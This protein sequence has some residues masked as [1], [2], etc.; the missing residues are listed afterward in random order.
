MILLLLILSIHVLPNGEARI[1]FTP[2][3]PVGIVNGEV[4][5][6][7]DQSVFGGIVAV[8]VSGAA[9]DESGVV[10]LG[11][12]RAQI[13]FGSPT[14]SI[15]VIAGR[16]ILTIR[17]RLKGEPKPESI[18]IAIGPSRWS[19]VGVTEIRPVVIEPGP[20]PAAMP[21]EEAEW[22]EA[23]EYR[24]MMPKVRFHTARSGLFRTFVGGGIALRNPN[25]IPVDVSLQTLDTL[26]S[27]ME[28]RNVRLAANEPAFHPIAA[29]NNYIRV[30]ATAEIEMVHLRRESSNLG[31]GGAVSTV[32]MSGAEIAPV[33]FDLLGEAMEW[34]WQTGSPAPAP[35]SMEVRPQLKS[36]LSRA[37]FSVHY[38]A[39]WLRVTPVPGE[40]E[41]RL[42]VTV[43]PSGLAP[44]TYRDTI[45]IQPSPNPYVKELAPAAVGVT[46]TVTA[47][48]RHRLGAGSLAFSR[49]GLQEYVTSDTN[50]AFTTRVIASGP[51]NWL[52]A[53]Y[54]SRGIPGYVAVAVNGEQLR[55]GVHAGHVILRGTRSTDV[56]QV[57]STIPGGTLIESP[58]PVQFLVWRGG[59]GPAPQSFPLRQGF[60]V[61][62]S[63]QT[64]GGLNW[65]SA[66]VRQGSLILSAN[67]Q[68]LVTGAYTGVVTL[69]SASAS[70]PTQI[71]VALLVYPEVPEP[72]V[73]MPGVIECTSRGSS[74]IPFVRVLS[75]I[76]ADPLDISVATD[77]GGDWLRLSNADAV[78]WQFGYS[79][80]AGSLAPGVYTGQ[81]RLKTPVQ[82]A[83]VPVRFTVFEPSTP[84]PPYL[85]AILNTASHRETAI[86]PNQEIQI[87]ASNF[88]SVSLDETPIVTSLAPLPL[89]YDVPG[90][91]GERQETT[92][93]VGNGGRFL[94]PVFPVAPAAPGVYTLDGSGKGTAHA[95][96]GDGTLNNAG[97]PAARNAPL[98]I[99]AT[100]VNPNELAVRFGETEGRVLSVFPVEE[101][102]PGRVWV[103]VVVP[104]AAPAGEVPLLLVSSGAES[105]PGVT[106]HIE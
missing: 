6:E 87:F 102:R 9:G 67:S 35:K 36:P 13:W 97:H 68:G 51:A 69:A 78:R 41:G 86:A 46:L 73:A 57:T 38:S 92:L 21:G 30:L 20:V 81:V 62:A 64:D 101:G 25:P 77:S 8:A 56:I 84:N 103:E 14:G 71:P 104:G 53:V 26:D 66:E 23:G 34:V 74:L 18:R 4:T 70:G 58:G 40:R 44:G 10:T 22:V 95:R 28:E 76:M 39:P 50:Q 17:A 5:V 75:G 45:R 7:L 60:V 59:A 94:E 33:G 11:G 83:T 3:R 88:T 65:L 98:W 49:S 80:E 72:I 19:S 55:A 82:S 29:T 16:P 54:P 47:E 91:L 31:A 37:G 2:D 93:R 99:M 105:Q 90:R 85:G 96:N 32:F 52:T 12:H 43:N 1:R 106:I 24:V 61:G 89:A 79:C 42:T 15:G 27:A 48:P 63:V 100:G